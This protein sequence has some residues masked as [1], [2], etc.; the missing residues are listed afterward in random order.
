MVAM[1]RVLLMAIIGNFIL[2]AL[3]GTLVPVGL[4]AIDRDPAVGSGVIVTATTDILGFL[5][6]LG[7]AGLL[8]GLL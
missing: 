4:D 3:I 1:A 7:F 6:F 5:Q 2:G 8:L